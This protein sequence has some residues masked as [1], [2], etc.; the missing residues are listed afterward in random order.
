MEWYPLTGESLNWE[1]TLNRDR[2]VVSEHQRNIK[3][4]LVS[5][6]VPLH[7]DEILRRLGKPATRATRNW[8]NS[9]LAQWAKSG[10]E[11]VKP[12]PQT[13]GLRAWSLQR[14]EGRQGSKSARAKP[15]VTR[16]IESKDCPSKV[17]RK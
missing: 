7:Y 10:R 17:R 14:I 15:Q 12:A 11:F 3:G 2:E 13:V 6:S 5:S 8:L 4:F 9:K 1:L 16:T